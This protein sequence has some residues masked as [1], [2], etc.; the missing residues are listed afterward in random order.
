MVQGDL[1]RA[2]TTRPF[3]GST[4]RVVQTSETASSDSSPR[5]GW[6]PP[7]YTEDQLR[8]ITD[9]VLGYSGPTNRR[10][11]ASAREHGV[12]SGS[13]V[14]VAVLAVAAEEVL[15]AGND[16]ACEDVVSTIRDLAKLRD[17]VAESRFSAAYRIAVPCKALKSS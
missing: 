7:E 16:Q 17:E 14:V 13:P 2:S 4:A 10:L 3:A 6:I 1:Q 9:A 5:C 15:V 8:T 12:V 11:R